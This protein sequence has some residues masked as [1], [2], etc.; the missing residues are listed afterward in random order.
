MENIK[1][2]DLYYLKKDFSL[3]REILR[4]IKINLVIDCIKHLRNNLEIRK[5]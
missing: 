4:T 3:K 5:E 2:G 1:P